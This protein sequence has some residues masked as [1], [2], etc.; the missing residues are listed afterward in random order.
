MNNLIYQSASTL[1]HAIKNK[2]IS[3]QAL[4]EAH[5]QH[6]EKVNPALNALINW[7]PDHARQQAL[8][9]DKAISQGKI[10]G[11]LLG[12]PISIKD[13]MDV[14]GYNVTM[15]TLGYAHHFTA[16]DAPI[17]A[18][19]RSEG[20]IIL[21]LTNMPEVAVAFETDNLIY[22]RTNN[23]YDLTRTPGGSSGGQAAIIAAGGSVLGLGGDGA[24]SIRVP[25]HFSGIA[26]IKP[27]HGRISNTG[28]LI[29]RDGCGCEPFI[30]FGPLARYVDDV[31][32]ALSIIAGPDGHD[33]FL[34]PV[35][36][37]DPTHVNLKQLKIAFFTDNGVVTP[38]A[39]IIAV[40]K[41][42][43]QQL[44]QQGLA[45]DEIQLP[46]QQNTFRLLWEGIFEGGDASRSL[47]DFLHSI[48]TQQFSPLF[49]RYL[50][51]SQQF[52]LTLT[53]FQTLLSDI[54]AYRMKM[55]Q[56]LK[57]YD[58]IIC[59]PCATTA[60]KHGTTFD[61][62]RDFTYT[63]AYNLTGWP[64]GVV[65]CGTSHEG[66]PIGVQIVGK[67]WREDHVLCV[68]KYLETVFGGWQAPTLI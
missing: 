41:N 8:A 43:A 9:I 21:G 13:T 22:G 36:L 26:G 59:P 14:K 60:R 68:A 16:D 48:G 20:A 40:V 6:I 3:T 19:L 7:Q 49:Q 51:Q 25:C 11:K 50:A 66:L 37:H 55:L 12:V 1:V 65:R 18:R 58:V 27:T 45:V 35:P 39:D 61:N 44:Q 10:A 2:I 42:A 24:G 29:P 47:I 46:D 31:T 34:V 32:L 5:I 38:E 33:P 28:L 15:G 56:A 23:P 54:A 64:A 30:S 63:M 62:M 17:V 4:V 57:Q 53:E 52:N 67:S